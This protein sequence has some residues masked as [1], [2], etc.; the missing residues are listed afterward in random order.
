MGTGAMPSASPRRLVGHSVVMVAVG[1]R[2]N[3]G[4][5]ETKTRVRRVA[6]RPTAGL[7][8]ECDDLLGGGQ[9]CLGVR[10]GGLLRRR[11]NEAGSGRLRFGAAVYPRRNRDGGSLDLGDR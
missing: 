7:W 9:A 6:V 1:R 4:A 5:A 8:G 11:L 10:Q 2:G 3:W